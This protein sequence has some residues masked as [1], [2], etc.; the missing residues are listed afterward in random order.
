MKTDLNASPAW[1][2]SSGASIIVRPIRAL[3]V[4]EDELY[5]KM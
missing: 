5:R 1:A 2:I 4:M 3:D